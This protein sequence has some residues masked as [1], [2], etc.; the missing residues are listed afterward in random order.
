M[1]DSEQLAVMARPRLE[2]EQVTVRFG[3]T[4]AVDA[5]DL[6]ASA[7]ETLAVV[8]PSGCGKTTLLRA[9]AG[10]QPI[11]AGRVV[12]EGRDLAGVPV[13]RRGVGLMFQEHALF[14][15]RDVAGNVA[16]GL[17]MQHQASDGI[18]RRV[19][20]LLA[21]VGLPGTERRAI[22]DL[23]GGEQQRVALAR[24]LAPSPSVLLLD[25]ALGALDRTLRERLASELRDL[26]VELGLTVV[27]VTHDQR[28]AF[29]LGDRLAVMDRGRLLQVGPPADV[30]SRPASAR[31]AELLGLA[32][33]LEVEVADGTAQAPWGRFAV[34]GPDGPAQVLV[35]PAAIVLDPDGP[36]AAHV[37]DSRFEGPRAALV[38]ELGGPGGAALHADVP[39]SERPERGATVHLRLVPGEV[40]RLGS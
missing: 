2:L 24:T 32:N 7:G 5:V 34:P 23:S 33:V 13:H 8:G 26:F 6:A 29:T 14:P 9:V 17:R 1:S 19:H 25:E 11:D 30:W 3:E 31:V 18:G 20:E 36:I 15:H 4:V 27:A 40:V 21:M 38:L 16:F 37:R 22:R 35:R 12:V 10:L 39:S 28:E